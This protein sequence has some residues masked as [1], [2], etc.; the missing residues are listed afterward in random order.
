MLSPPDGPVLK[1]GE[2]YGFFP[3]GKI[4]ARS[5]GFSWFVDLKPMDSATM[6]YDVYFQPGFDFTYG[7]KLPGLAGFDAPR[8]CSHLTRTR[9]WSHRLMWQKHGGMVT[10]GYYPSKPQSIRCGENWKWNQGVQT[11]RW[12]N[13]RIFVA[14]NTAGVANGVSKAWLDGRLVLDKRN[15]MYRFVD[16]PEYTINKAYITTYVG[17]S[18][19]A[20]FAPDHD[21]HIKF[22]NFNIWSGQCDTSTPPPLPA[23]TYTK[24]HNLD[25][26]F[27]GDIAVVVARN[28]SCEKSCDNTRGC[29]VFTVFRGKCYLKRLVAAPVSRLPIGRDAFTLFA[30][31]CG[32]PGKQCCFGTSCDGAL[33]CAS[34]TCIDTSANVVDQSDL[35][36]GTPGQQCCGIA[37]DCDEDLICQ[38]TTCQEGE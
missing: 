18:S 19:V 12:H 20:M 31:N 13:I 4:L 16:K 29:E 11:G 5:T 37:G 30:Q 28:S 25:Q 26:P 3:K 1:N 17:G 6:S 24:F 33:A 34:G 7:G 9:G 10:Y 35:T 36:C 2:L 21:Q 32:T 15:I 14:I 27:L 23:N 22:D 8:G 38:H